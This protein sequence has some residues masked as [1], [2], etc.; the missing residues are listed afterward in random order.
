MKNR[1]LLLNMLILCGVAFGPLQAQSPDAQP[2]LSFHGRIVDDATNEPLPFATIALLSADS[3]V[4]AG[5]VAADDGSFVL[6]AKDNKGSVLAFSFIG[7]NTAYRA[8]PTSKDAIEVRLKPSATMLDAVRITAKAPVIEQQMDKLVMNVAQSA[9]AQGN[10]ALD[11]LRK[12]PG[13]SIDKDGNVQL[14]GQ[15]VE[16]WIDGRP[17]QLDGKSLEAM[18]RATDGTSIDKIEVIANPSAKYDAAGQGGII[19]IKTKRNFMQGF[20]GTL[21]ANLAG[22]G[23][24]RDLPMVDAVNKFYFDQDL[25]L[26]L[27]YRTSKT[28]TYLQL[29]EATTRLGVDVVS[30][31]DLSAVNQDFYQ[32]SVS[33]YD[34]NFDVA[35]L[36]LGN[37]WFIDKKN[38]LGVILT[39]PT[40]RMMQCADTDGNRSYQQ[41]S[42]AV[43]QQTMSYAKTD[44]RFSQYMGNLN[45]THIFN[46]AK[47]SELTANLDYMHY[48][49]NSSNPLDNYILAPSQQL[50]WLM[51]SLRTSQRIN[52]RSDNVVDVYS[53]KVDWQG[54]VLGMLMMEAGGKYALTHTDNEMERSEQ[55]NLL[56]PVLATTQF[57]YTEHIGAL[58]ATL[59]GMH[60]RGF[61]AKVGL[62]GE[63]TYAYNSSNTVTQNYFDLFPT[64]YFGYAT[65]DMKK[66]F[67]I[68]Y[69]RRIQR[70][71]YSQLNPF[72]NF[73]DAHT[74]NRGNPD[75]RPSYANNINLNAGFGHHL[76]LGANFIFIKDAMDMTPQINPL[77]GEQTLLFDNVGEN[78]LMGGS[79]TLSEL[80]IGK[81]LTLM[82]N[83]NLY[84]YHSHTHPA[85]LLY[86][87]P[88]SLQAIDEHHL[89]ASSYACLTLT[90]PRAWK[91]QLDGYLSSPVNQGY[92]H[93]GWH[94]S[95]NFAVKKTAL[96]GRLLFTFS[97]N[98]LFRTQNTTFGI[99]MDGN[100][101]SFYRQNYLNQTLKVGL[102]WNF[103]TAQQP[104]K[105]RKVGELDEAA[106]TQSRNGLS[107]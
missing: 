59:A 47:Q 42:G 81:Y 91:L 16:V 48:I 96:D 63:Y 88:S 25:S 18:L 67:G 56:S 79:V 99:Y 92:M 46:E 75:L 64:A 73:I 100:E 104:L 66:R 3:T 50:T 15:A 39:L 102:Q 45:Y 60:P 14:N 68:S 55:T 105:H 9:F 84:D 20:N 34:A 11:L 1:I 17:S 26:N 93:V 38:T 7:Y 54:L 41:V 78:I 71:S 8:L 24:H 74:S 89:F 77:T 57:D 44:Y 2:R 31:T 97:V 37:D 27:N 65:P 12:A 90:L 22:M 86:N 94:Y 107:N 72:Q 83:A 49:N 28:N 6:D 53:A 106:R 76:T 19:N 82:V 58:Y 62:R 21:N 5:T 101:I 13:V 52:L 23:F 98:D 36:K 51:D 4:L 35:S 70:P 43:T 32:K 85:Q 40:T 30:T 80:P 95:T 69:T 10:N 87:D 103:G 29:S 33:R 61:T